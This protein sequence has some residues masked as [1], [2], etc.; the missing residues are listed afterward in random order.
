MLDDTVYLNEVSSKLR[1]GQMV[2]IKDGPFAGVQGRIVRIRKSRR[3]MVELDGMLA[4][5]ATYNPTEEL[6]LLK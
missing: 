1:E 3:I 6:E 4:V 5:A 2:T